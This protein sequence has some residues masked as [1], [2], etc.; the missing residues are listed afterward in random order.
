MNNAIRSEQPRPGS[1]WGAGT[2]LLLPRQ[3]SQVLLKRLQVLLGL[4]M[5]KPNLL[6][7]LYGRAARADNGCVARFDEP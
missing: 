3:R 5:H 2:C 4:E 6:T 1:E 7:V